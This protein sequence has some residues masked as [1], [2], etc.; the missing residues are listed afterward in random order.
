MWLPVT[1][2]LVNNPARLECA[3]EVPLLLP[4]PITLI[5]YNRKTL[6]GASEVRKRS[7]AKLTHRKQEFMMEKA[8]SVVD[9]V[10]QYP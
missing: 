5:T 4:R 2:R 10:H 1:V 3:S 9:R 8:G 6:G 7:E